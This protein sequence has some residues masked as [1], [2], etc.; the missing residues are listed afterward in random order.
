[1]T[2]ASFWLFP[3]LKGAE[4][5]Y[6]SWMFRP[7]NHMWKNLTDIPVQDFKNCFEK[8]PKHWVHWKEL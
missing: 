4:R 8:W 7:L 6:F 5:K 1:L 2:P 3:K